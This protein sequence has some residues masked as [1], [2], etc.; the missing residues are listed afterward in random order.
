MNHYPAWKNLLILGIVVVGAFIAAPN[1]FGDDPPAVVVSEARLIGLE[2]LA[3]TWTGDRLVTEFPDVERALQAMWHERF[4]RYRLEI[5]WFDTD[6]TPKE[7]WV[8]ATPLQDMAILTPST[9][10]GAT[11][12]ATGCC[13]PT[14]SACSA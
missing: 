7:A 8:A 13:L 2:P 12:R 1:L 11:S 3:G 4:A 5:F 14:R 9:S 6:T 10:S